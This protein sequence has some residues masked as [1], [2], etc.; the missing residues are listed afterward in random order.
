ML[1][2]SVRL[3]VHERRERTEYRRRLE[4]IAEGSYVQN[5][6]LDKLATNGHPIPFVN[7]LLAGDFERIASETQVGVEKIERIARVIT[8]RNKVKDLYSLQQVEVEDVVDVQLKVEGGEY[9]SL[10]ELSH[11]QK[12]MVILMVALAEGESPLVVDQPE[13]ALHAPGIEK[14]IVGTLRSERGGRQCVFATLNGNI[15]VSADAEQIIALDS[16]ASSGWVASTGC[17]DRFDHRELVVYHVE[18]GEEAFERR[19][20]MYTLEVVV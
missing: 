6:D 1:D 9:R 19:Q 4:Q 2:H 7:A 11:G 10:E 16:N 5:T 13:D 17:L 14:G 3:R 12:C 20:A 15:L 8:D 18:G